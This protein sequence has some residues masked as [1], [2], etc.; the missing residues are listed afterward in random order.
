MLHLITC[1]R[2]IMPCLAE[3][4]FASPE[5]KGKLTLNLVGSIRVT[6]RVKTIKSF[7]LEILDGHNSCDLENL[8]LSSSREPKS[9]LT[10]NLV[11]SIGVG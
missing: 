11:G 2:R 5:P 8:F 7:R 6:Y 1:H 9:Q 4:L 10:G 3:L